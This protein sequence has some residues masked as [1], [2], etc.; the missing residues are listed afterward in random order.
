MKRIALWAL[1]LAIPVVLGL[2]P[3]HGTDAAKLEPAQILLLEATDRGLRIRTDTGAVGVGA[4]PE[5]ALSDLEQ[6]AQGVLFLQTAETLVLT[7]D[8]LSYLP[9]AAR[10]QKLRP[11]AKVYALEGELPE[12]KEAAEFLAGHSAGVTLGQVRASLLG[13]GS[14]TLPILCNSDGRLML[15][16]P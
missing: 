13:A 2:L 6:T 14:V 3:L 10:S 5:Q 1:L 15:I 16:A 9:Q 8:A 4:D 7:K 12:A 11:A